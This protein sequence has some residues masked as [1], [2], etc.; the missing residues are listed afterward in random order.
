MGNDTLKLSMLAS[1]CSVKE[2]KAFVQK[3]HFW[4]EG[5]V[6]MQ[7]PTARQS[8]AYLISVIDESLRQSLERAG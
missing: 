8:Y 1:T 6:G 5:E 3:W 7:P 4:M 2:Y